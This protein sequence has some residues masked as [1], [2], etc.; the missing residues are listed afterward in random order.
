MSLVMFI[1][2]GSIMKVGW[3]KMSD[4]E[5]WVSG[6]WWL[7]CDRKYSLLILRAWTSGFCVVSKKWATDNRHPVG[8][9]PLPMIMFKLGFINTECEKSY[10]A[11]R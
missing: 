10:E 11:V 2:S 1:G 4:Q 3:A 9:L 7:I 5:H 6:H 8:E